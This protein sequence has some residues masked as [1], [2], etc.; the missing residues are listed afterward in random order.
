MTT[1]EHD[2]STATSTGYDCPLTD[3]DIKILNRRGLNNYL[4]LRTR[5]FSIVDMVIAGEHAKALHATDQTWRDSVLT[6]NA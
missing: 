5:D 6:D 1:N 4:V 2:A 3:E